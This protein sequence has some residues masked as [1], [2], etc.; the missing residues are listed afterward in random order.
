MLALEVPEK[1]GFT[2]DDGKSEILK[3]YKKKNFLKNSP[4]N[5]ILHAICK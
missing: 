4:I 2:S 1:Q 5:L 3:D